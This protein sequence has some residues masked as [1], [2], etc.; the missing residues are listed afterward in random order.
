M[1]DEEWLFTSDVAARL[2]I[3]RKT[4]VSY[5]TSANPRLP[6]PDRYFGRTPAWRPATIKKYLDHMPPNARA[7][8][9]RLERES[10]AGAP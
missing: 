2:H 8:W 5:Y 1:P 7:R 3:T 9:Q 6:L 4:V 10:K